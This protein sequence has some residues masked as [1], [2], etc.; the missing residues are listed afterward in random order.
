MVIQNQLVSP[1][2]IHMQ[3]TLNKLSVLYLNIYFFNVYATTM[4]KKRGGLMNV[5]G[6]E[7]YRRGR[8]KN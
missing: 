5:G 7:G 4:A 3:A 6:S 8:R 1:R 2:N